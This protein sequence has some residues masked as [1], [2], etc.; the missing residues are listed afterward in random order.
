MSRTEKANLFYFLALV[1]LFVL[2]GRLNDLTQFG[3]F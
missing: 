2:W 1:A 3:G